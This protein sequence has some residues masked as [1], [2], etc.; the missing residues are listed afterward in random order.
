M[1]ILSYPFFQKALL[2]GS[3]VSILCGLI[4]VFVMLRR[5]SFIGAGISHAAFGGVAIGFFFGF[6]PT[7]SA[8]IYAILTAFFINQVVKRGKISED[9]AIGIFFSASMAIG[10]IFIGLTK[11]NTVD[12]FG[13]LFGNI[14]TVETGELNIMLFSFL[15]IFVFILLNFKKLYIT[16]FNEELAYVSGV[17]TKRLALYL[18]ILLSFVIVLSMKV[19]GLI[20][21]SALLVIPAACAKMVSRNIIFMTLI[22]VFTAILSTITGLFLSFYLN[23]PSGGTI[24]TVLAILFFAALLAKSPIKIK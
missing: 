21:V 15:I 1:E 22:S 10:V 8:V 6:N 20:L 16:S 11:N 19:V 9:T 14:L 13:Y 12:L 23:L 24:V 4:S 5:M 2:A 3:M 7:I 17:D 18:L